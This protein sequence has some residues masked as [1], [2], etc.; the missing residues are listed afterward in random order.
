MYAGLFAKGTPKGRALLAHALTSFP[1]AASVHEMQDTFVPV[2][3]NFRAYVLQG[4]TLRA[5]PREGH[6]WHTH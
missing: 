6:S 2:E 3:T 5:R 1:K 4:C